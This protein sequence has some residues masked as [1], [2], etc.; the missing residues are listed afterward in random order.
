[1][2]PPARNMNRAGRKRI[3]RHAEMFGRRSG[4]RLR[5]GSSAKPRKSILQS[6]LEL[7]DDGRNGIAFVRGSRPHSMTLSVTTAEI[8]RFTGS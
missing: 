1:M 3:L 7:T 4:V 2:K 5:R 6:D 8:T